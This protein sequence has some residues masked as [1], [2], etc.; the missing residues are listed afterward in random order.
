MSELEEM[1]KELQ[2]SP[3]ELRE[4]LIQSRESGETIEGL[5]KE[6]KLLK[7]QVE[8]H[9]YTIR[10]EREGFTLLEKAIDELRYEDVW[11]K[12]AELR[13]QNPGK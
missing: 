10:K 5:E 9:E 1:V 13:D 2:K 3:S 11:I 12:Y 8:M 7:A 6:N 4:L